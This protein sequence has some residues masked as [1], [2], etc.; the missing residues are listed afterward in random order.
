MQQ[1]AHLQVD[2]GAPLPA[3]AYES[4]VPLV[5]KGY[6]AAWPAVLRAV[7][8]AEALADYLSTFDANKPLTVYVG[9]AAMRGRFFY[10]ADCTGF[11]FR[12][13]KAS[14]AQVLA[15]LLGPKVE[16][17][18][19]TI[20]VGST[21]VDDWLPG[22]RAANDVSLPV[23]DALA[24]FWLGGPTSVSAHFDFPDNLACVVAGRR[25]F[26]LFPPEQL[27]NLYV[28]PIDR[29]PSGQMIS[30]VDFDAPDLQ[31]F[32]RFAQAQQHALIADLEPGDA[33]F[34]PS[35]WWHHVRASAPFNLLVNYWWCTTPASMGAPSVA[36]SHAIL[37]LRELPAHQ[38]RAW[39]HLF[40]YYVFEA[41][42]RNFEHIPAA[43]RGMLNPLDEETIRRV[44]AELVQRLSQ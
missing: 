28:G 18:I 22:F 35:M 33:L 8:S 24:S 32:P 15:R 10:D 5:L 20:Y 40:D 34:V 2:A 27:H 19:D 31:R 25:R 37:A 39:K 3:A 26:T 21:P 9:D 6:V 44:R 16:D 23:N 30:L 38:R 29:T 13:G 11:N 1:V 17:N 43:G 4:T 7:D 12:S 41:D 42:E 36:L 14:L